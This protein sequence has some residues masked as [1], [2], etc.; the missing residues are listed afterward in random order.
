ME[1]KEQTET[2]Q[3]FELTKE[4]A[5]AILSR[6]GYGST[7]DHSVRK[8]EEGMMNDVFSIGDTFVIKV[9]TGHPDLPKLEKEYDVMQTMH[10][11][12]V[13][14]PPVYAYD[15]TKETVP[16]PYLLMGFVTGETLSTVSATL[17]E[18]EREGVTEKLGEILGRIHAV[19]YREHK[20]M[21]TEKWIASP[22]IQ[23]RVETALEKLR[24]TDLL[25]DGEKKMITDLYLHSDTFKSDRP[26]S[27]LHGN[28]SPANVLVKDNEVTGVIDWEFGSLGD[29]EEELAVTLY[30]GLPSDDLSETFLNGYSRFHDV[31]GDFY[32]RYLGYVL[33]YF[34]KILPDVPKWTHKPEKQKEYIDETKILIEKIG[35]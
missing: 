33:L 21:N 26:R 16:Y 5:N 30:R 10:T 31:R 6:T 13:P 7:D 27:I 19:D 14:V 12:E 22:A 32:D 8:F 29:A 15:D 28:F 34:L 4:Q 1:I 2:F 23:Q 3:S 18:K 17:G 11:A 35:G 20:N 25:S 9:N 24:D